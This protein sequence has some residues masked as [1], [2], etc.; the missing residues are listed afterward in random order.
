MEALFSKV[1]RQDRVA[2]AK[3]I[4]MVESIH[5]KDLES[6][7]ELLSAASS[8][9]SSS[10]RIAITGAPGVGK[11]CLIEN[12][13]LELIRQGHRVAVLAVDPSSHRTGGSILGD[14]TRMPK[15]STHPMAFVRPSPTSGMLG[16]IGASTSEIMVLCE[17]A[18]FDRI[19]VETVGVGQSEL[20]V[21]TICDVVCF[22]TLAGG[23][24]SLQG[25]K[26]GIL[27]TV[28]V[29]AVNKA[30]GTNHTASVNYASQLEGALHLLHGNGPSPKA[31]VT[32]ALDNTGIEDLLKEIDHIVSA[33][34]LDGSFE[35]NRQAQRE[36]W[37]ESAF[38]QA[39]NR[40]VLSDSFINERKKDLLNQVRA[41]TLIPPMAAHQL[42]NYWRESLE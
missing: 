15:L 7:L 32:S 17:A 12:I 29:V 35:S 37:F 5:Q 6:R 4:T 18:G 19:I 13:G 36:I 22:V 24:D 21:S 33:K 23:G 2:L 34:K 28:D 9:P 42:L 8:V 25:I 39:F 40:L 10:V 20:A 38:M 30:D 27:E 14:K 11:S 41:N 26:R 1:Q 3:A 16:G 31:Q